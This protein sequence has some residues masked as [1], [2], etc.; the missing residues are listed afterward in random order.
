MIKAIA[1]LTRRTDLT[2][3]EF[4]DHYE[5]SHA[6]LIRRLLPQIRDYRRNFVDLAGA[7]RAPGV[8]DPGFD[9]ITEFWFDDRAGYDAMLATYAQ[10]EICAQIEADEIRFLDR[11]KTI[12]FLVDELG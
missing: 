6:P 1:L 8:P 5:N 9:V 10:P 3:A 4:I 7:V 2:R 11:D 12:Q